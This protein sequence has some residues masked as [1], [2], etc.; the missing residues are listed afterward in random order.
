MQDEHTMTDDIRKRRQ[1]KNRIIVMLPLL[2]LIL[3]AACGI[4]SNQ[5][6]YKSALI[7]RT[8][9]P[10]YGSADQDSAEGWVTMEVTSAIPIGTAERKLYRG[11]SK[12]GVP[13]TQSYHS[14]YLVT[15][16]EAHTVVY[17]QTSDSSVTAITGQKN[18][19]G[20]NNEKLPMRIYG[21]VDNFESYF[22][23]FDGYDSMK[24]YASFDLITAF[25][26]PAQASRLVQSDSDRNMQTLL[27]TFSVVF[28][29]G[30][31][32]V[33]V[34]I[35]IRIQRIRKKLLEARKRLEE[36]QND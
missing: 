22:K 23:S 25:R 5:F 10:V 28:V 7:P 11:N 4:L 9:F 33:W 19:F 13:L 16:S 30:A 35:K 2:L 14:M 32:G 36:K 8:E 24:E 1:R 15:D 29:M 20:E 6:G 26:Y 18:L 27:R 34:Y 12:M 17:D 3:A 31:V 21:R